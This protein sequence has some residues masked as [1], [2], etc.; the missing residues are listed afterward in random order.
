MN[1]Y[2]AKLPTP[3]AVLG[4]I[5]EGEMLA[6]IDFLPLRSASLAPQNPLAQEVCR[7][8][9]AYV[10]HP[11]FQFDL[12]LRL[13]GT[14]HRLKVWRALLA[15]PRGETR[16]YG[17]IAQ[18]LASSPR[19]VGQACGANPIPVVVPCHRVLAKHG[20]G[21]FMKHSSGD[22]LRI[23]HWLLRHEADEPGSA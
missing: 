10:A 17:D 9:L 15:I 18:V 22:P 20:A 2:Q 1:H 3:F 7:Q 11:D 21:G 16:C 14:A 12:P 6:G 4:I 13:D 19:A 5:T 8:L 23:K